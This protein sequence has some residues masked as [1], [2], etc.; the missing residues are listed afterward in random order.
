MVRVARASRLPFSASRG[1]QRT[2]RDV[3]FAKWP[4]PFRKER[5]TTLDGPRETR[6]P[7]GGTPALPNA[8]ES[9]KERFNFMTKKAQSDAGCCGM[10]HVNA[11]LLPRL[12]MKP[13]PVASAVVLASV[14][15]S[16]VFR[17]PVLVR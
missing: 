16:V 12:M 9:W 10:A 14:V 2:S 11:P 15:A 5:R 13:V 3:R 4:A 17:Q 8:R 6:G 1:E 7:A